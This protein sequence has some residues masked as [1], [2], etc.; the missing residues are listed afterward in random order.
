MFSYK[1]EHLNTDGANSDMEL[2]S[3]SGGEVER[4]AADAGR[5]GVIAYG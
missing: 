4:E 5:P 1:G 3:G 2:C